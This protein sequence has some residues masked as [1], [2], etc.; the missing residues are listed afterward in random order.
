MPQ[1]RLGS[2]ST[3]HV[4]WPSGYP[5]LQED[6]SLEN[7][8]KRVEDS[9]KPYGLTIKLNLSELHLDHDYYAHSVDKRASHLFQLLTNPTVQKI[10]IGKGGFGGIETGLRLQKL[11]KKTD[12]RS[13]E[14]KWIIGFS[15]ATLWHLW[16][17]PLDWP[18]LHAPN[19][20]NLKE[21]QSNL[22]ATQTN[23]ATPCE[24]LLTLLNGQSHTLIHPLTHWEGDAFHS[25]EKVTL[26]GG[27]LSVIIRNL[28]NPLFSLAPQDL[29]GKILFLEDTSEDWA[30]AHSLLTSLAAS[31]LLQMA[32][33]IIFGDYPLEGKSL[34][35]TITLWHQGIL[36]ETLG[37]NL[38]IYR[39]ENCGH[40]PRNRPLPLNYEGEI[41]TKNNSAS[42][43]FYL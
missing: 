7:L 16:S 27:N 42:L 6:K 24:E 34:R 36:R 9:V 22:V 25:N 1:P 3:V 11:I 10:W 17:R 5:L 15:D 8:Q 18:F 20:I 37:L 32:R 4:A 13:L 35:E 14:K 30:R 21:I 19:V 40:G 38:P 28:S 39:L 41:M 23:H 26:L 29:E 31:G 33:G 12:N 2:S 43:H